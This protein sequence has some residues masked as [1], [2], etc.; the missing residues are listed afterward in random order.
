[1]GN[2][3]RHDPGRLQG[4]TR[5]RSVTQDETGPGSTLSRSR[6]P[7]GVSVSFVGS[8]SPRP[9]PVHQTRQRYRGH[10]DGR[11]DRTLF[12]RPVT[13]LSRTLA[14]PVSDPTNPLACRF[15]RRDRLVAK[16]DPGSP[17]STVR[18]VGQGTQRPLVR[19]R[20]PPLSLTSPLRPS[21]PRP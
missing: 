13:R 17:D 18:G 10:G 1:M 14:G 7:P 8:P 19:P 21:R 6:G 11:S 3:E 15:T 20:P 16:S 9:R 12:V 2:R 5:P 4:P